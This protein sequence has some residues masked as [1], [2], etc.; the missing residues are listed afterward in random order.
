MIRQQIA[1]LADAAECLVI[2][3]EPPADDFPADIIVVPGIRY[4]T[5]ESTFPGS[6]T[7]AAI[8]ASAIIDAIARKWK[9][10]CDICHVHNPLLAKNRDFLQILSILQERDLRLFLQIHDFAENGRPDAYFSDKPYPSD[11]H[12]GVINSRDSDIL[13]KAGLAEPGVH[14]I[15]NHIEPLATVPKKTIPDDL[16]LYP[17]RAIKRKNIGEALLMALFFPQDRILAI[18]LP[19]NSPKDWRAYDRWRDFQAG[20]AIRVW[21]E[22]AGRYAFEE[23]VTAST[24]MI[25]TSVTEGF[26]F[27][28]L[29]P[30][31]A[32]RL[33]AGRRIDHVCRDFEKNGLFLDHLYSRILIPVRAFDL[34]RF[35]DKWQACIQ[36]NAV[37]FNIEMDPIRI[38]GAFTALTRD[39]CIDFGFLDETGQEQVLR[40]LLSDGD[41]KQ[42]IEHRNPFL[43]DIT[44]VSEPDRRI[45]ENREAVLRHYSRSG[46]RQRMID[47]YEAVI[48]TPVRHCIDKQVLAREFLQPEHFHLIH[49]ERDH[50]L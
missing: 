16:V 19:P 38:T 30:W 36:N 13:R 29:E 39:G 22:A 8:T 50:D 26:G 49:W 6:E 21:F 47:I 32:N 12:Y 40:N 17:V 3:G 25:S 4:T 24:C 15:P 18:T 33:L 20:H 34:G 35:Y 14:L 31:T 45:R 28:F 7:S 23:L 5:P 2:T 46:H 27:A 37:R 43:A 1:S 44:R 41:L 11:C 48:W 10:G 42:E 9:N